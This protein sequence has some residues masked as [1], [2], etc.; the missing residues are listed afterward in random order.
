M[1][2]PSEKS[3]PSVIDCNIFPEHLGHGL[4]PGQEKTLTAVGRFFQAD[5]ISNGE[6]SLV[7]ASFQAQEFLSQGKCTINAQFP[8][9]LDNVP[10][11]IG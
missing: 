11:T 4:T 1:T 9:N 10:Y 8:S 5:L 2:P 7:N 6:T 3:R